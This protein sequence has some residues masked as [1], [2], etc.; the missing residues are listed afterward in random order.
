M[1][2]AFSWKTT[3]GG[4]VAILTGLGMVGKILNDFM[5]GEPVNFEQVALAVGTIG[6][7]FGLLFARDN[8]VTSEEAGA[9]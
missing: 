9:K 7:G 8:T 2:T 6:T 1:R 5:L 4:V 3:I